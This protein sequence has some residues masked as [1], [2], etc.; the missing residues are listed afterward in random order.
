MG[1][2]PEHAVAEWRLAGRPE[3]DPA[4]VSISLLCLV[5]HEDR[6]RQRY[7]TFRTTPAGLHACI[8]HWE[9]KY[10]A[11]LGWRN[12][13]YLPT[14][15]EVPK[16]FDDRLYGAAGAAPWWLEKLGYR[17]NTNF[18]LTPRASATL[19]M[20]L[21]GLAS[22]ST[23]L[24]GYE[25]ATYDN[26]SNND[27]DVSVSGFVTNHQVTAI[28]ANTRGEMH[29]VT[30]IAD[31]VWPGV[32][33]GTTSA[34]TIGTQGD[35]DT[36]CKRLVSLNWDATTANVPRYH[37]KR[38]LAVLYGGFAPSKFVLFFT[39]NTG[40]NLH[41]TTAGTQTTKGVYLTGT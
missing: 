18:T 11:A 8:D 26:T 2:R 16:N 3:P 38:S 21:E 34:E 31:G 10:P 25:S 1:Q 7:H 41:N 5:D 29:V 32:F 9:H 36:T 35:K 6:E 30:E 20:A 37:T 19:T 27:I 12:H 17:E 22:S 15:R 40:Q 23:L 14:A 33:D 39:H 13:Q 24:A 4:A 28:T